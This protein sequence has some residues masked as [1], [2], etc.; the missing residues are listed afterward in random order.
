MTER[1]EPFLLCHHTGSCLGDVLAEL[2]LAALR[3]AMTQ[4]GVTTGV[5]AIN[6]A[7]AELVTDTAG[8]RRR[9]VP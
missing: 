3:T 6:I 1:R 4:L 7:L 5:E 2:D 9:R 8:S